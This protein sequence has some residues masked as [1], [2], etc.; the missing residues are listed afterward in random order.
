[1]KG[2]MDTGILKSGQRVDKRLLVNDKRVTMG[3]SD[4]SLSRGSSQRLL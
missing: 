3:E 2:T 4:Y 1:M